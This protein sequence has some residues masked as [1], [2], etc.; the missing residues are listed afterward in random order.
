M[1]KWEGESAVDSGVNVGCSVYSLL[2]P[3]PP[4]ASFHSCFGNTLHCVA[5]LCNPLTNERLSSAKALWVIL[6]KPMSFFF[7]QGKG[8]GGGSMGYFAFAFLFTLTNIKENVCNS[9]TK[10]WLLMLFFFLLIECDC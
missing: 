5:M 6:K 4:L 10:L 7:V 9:N 3:S 8:V 2:Y 1:H